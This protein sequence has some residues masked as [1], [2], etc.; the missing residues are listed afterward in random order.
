MQQQ[1]PS[2]A[3]RR[4]RPQTIQP[5]PT[6][7]G[8][9]LE[10]LWV[11]LVA[12]EDLPA[13]DSD[14]RVPMMARAGDDAAYVLGFKN[15]VKARAFVVSQDVEGAEPRM[16]VRSNRVDI[17]RIAQSAGATGV[18]VDYDPVSQQYAAAAAL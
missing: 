10:G 3:N 6:G 18:L 2:S 15:A 8:A 5:P 4:G 13:A 11:L 12:N 1:I 16:V 9:V 7:P 17:V 14:G